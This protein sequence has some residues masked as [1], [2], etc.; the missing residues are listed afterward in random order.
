[1]AWP[2]NII[3]EKDLNTTFED[4]KKFML[5]L[6]EPLDEYERIARNR[7][8]PGISKELPKVLMVL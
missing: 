6:H 4:A 5:P 7:P 8:H 2:S 1:V 3:T